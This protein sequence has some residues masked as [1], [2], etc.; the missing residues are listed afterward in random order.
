MTDEAKIREKFWKHLKSDRTIMLGLIGNP[1]GHSQPMTAQLDDDDVE[2]G[3]LWIFSSKDV[4]LVRAIGDGAR[5]MAQFVSKGHD[6]FACFDCDLSLTTDR[7]TIDRL[8][9]PYVAAWFEGGKDDPKLQ[10]IRLDPHHA[11]IWLNENSLFAGVKLMLG[12]DPKR[13]YADKVADTNLG[14]TRPS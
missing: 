10:L 1:E 7:A 9:N 8:W 4:D 5:G 2:G 11:Q 12:A 6:V 14:A 3:P 13:E